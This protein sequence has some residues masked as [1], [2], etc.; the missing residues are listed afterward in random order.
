MYSQV[1]S[2]IPNLYIIPLSLASNPEKV[3]ALLGRGG[4]WY[5][6]LSC[7][8]AELTLRLKLVVLLCNKIVSL[9]AAN[10]IQWEMTICNII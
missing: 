1:K 8:P 9:D 5:V 7:S 2:Q 3:S 6:P 4:A 10:E